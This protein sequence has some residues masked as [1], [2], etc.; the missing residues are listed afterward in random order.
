MC[1]ATAGLLILGIRQCIA[2]A[3]GPPWSTAIVLG[4]GESPF[5]FCPS[6][7]A[8]DEKQVDTRVKCFGS[9]KSSRRR[10]TVPSTSSWRIPI[11]VANQRL[12]HHRYKSIASPFAR[13][14]ILTC[15]IPACAQLAFQPTEWVTVP[16]SREVGQSWSSSVLTTAYSLVFSTCVMLRMRPQIVICNGPGVLVGGFMG[17]A[18]VVAHRLYVLERRVSL[19]CPR[20]LLAHMLRGVCS[21]RPWYRALT[22]HFCGELLSGLLALA[23][24]ETT[25]PHR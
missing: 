2:R 17:W 8:H 3:C 22:H 18:S 9:P 1:F 11:S 5:D 21:S 23:D 15:T 13:R 12:P 20:H 16:R 24:G 19:A 10:S 4:S 25:V 7:C 14:P 6:H